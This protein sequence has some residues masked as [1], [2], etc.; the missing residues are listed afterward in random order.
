MSTTYDGTT[1]G[2]VEARWQARWDA[3]GAYDAGTEVPVGEP[4]FLVLDMFP[5]PSAAGLHV[6]HPLGYVATDVAARF[7][8]MRGAHV[9]HA[10]GYDAFGLPAEQYAIETGLHPA[11]AT[12]DNVATYCAQTHRLGLGHD[13]RRTFT[14]TDPAYYRWTQWIFARI[15]DAWYDE[16]QD[17]AR[18]VAE[19]VDDYGSGRRTPP[20]PWAAMSPGERADLV[21]AHRLARRARSTVNWCPALGT[22]LADAEV[23]DDGRSERGNFPVHRR[24]LVQWELRITTYSQRLLRDL[25]PLDWP[26]SIKALQRHWITMPMHDWVFSRQR[27]WGEPFPVVYDEDDRPHLL[28]DDLLPV[29]L[30]DLASFAPGPADEHSDPVAPL[31][32]ATDWV[33]ATLDLGD[34][35][36]RYRRETSTMPQW[37]GSC[38]YH[39]WYLRDLTGDGFPS[40]DVLARWTGPADDKPLGGVDLYVGGAEHAVLHLLYARFWHKV[41]H[42]LGFVPSPEPF[43]RLVNQGY[44][45]AWAYRD[46]RGVPVAPADVVEADGGFRRASDGGGVTRTLGKMGKSLKNS[47]TPDELVDRFGADTFRLH[48]MS[49][50]PVEVSRVWETAAVVGSHRFLQ[51]L[52]RTVVAPDG[53]SRVTDHEPTDDVRAAVDALVGEAARGYPALRFNTIQPRANAAVT[54]LLR[55]GTTPRSAARAVV[56]ALFPLVPHVCAELWERMGETSPLDRGPFPVASGVHEPAEVTYPVQVAGRVRARVTVPSDASPDDV[57]RAAV[58]AVAG[59]LPTAYRV[60]VVPGRIVVVEPG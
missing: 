27:Y 40:P 28:P 54:L 45:Q 48:L 44:V 9:L 12:A 5:F 38:W 59:W 57:E 11:R 58:A 17:R 4:T 42:D 37:A 20:R 29:T 33:H 21:D 16:A 2:E 47:V 56:S 7:A 3:A 24:E 50:A 55:A 43:A 6:G 35:P 52:W 13:P 39:L 14:T 23:T 34:G 49:A 25:E 32:R 46:A 15:Y 26:E 36:R 30:P 41:L 18:P 60:R 19:L 51:R 10:L 1:A 8:R 53:T 22:V 31:E